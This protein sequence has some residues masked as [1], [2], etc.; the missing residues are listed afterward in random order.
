MREKITLKKPLIVNGA[1]KTELTY[2][3][4]EISPTLFAQ[5]D[6][7]KKQAAG[8][9]S[10][11][12]TPAVEFDFALHIYLGFAAIIAINPEITFEDLDRMKG[13]DLM[14]M[15]A[16]GRNFTLKVEGSQESNSDTCSETI[17]EPSTVALPNSNDGQ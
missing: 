4:E 15:N 6:A 5:A 17:P 9:K 16:I 8:Q 13:F 7:L 10:V 12:V 11:A 2:D 14:A 3:I 1:E